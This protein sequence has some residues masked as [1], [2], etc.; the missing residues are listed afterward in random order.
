LLPEHLPSE[1][2]RGMWRWCERPSER[3]SEGS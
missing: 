3:S 2:L 1:S